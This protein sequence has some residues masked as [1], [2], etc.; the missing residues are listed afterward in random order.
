MFTS[1]F[2]RAFFSE[3]LLFFLIGTVL[4]FSEQMSEALISFFLNKSFFYTEPAFLKLIYILL[5]VVSLVLFTSLTRSGKLT[6]I[7]KK[8]ALS[9]YL[10]F[11]LMGWLIGFSAHNY[12]VY[13]EMMNTDS[14]HDLENSYFYYLQDMVLVLAFAIAGW[15]HLK[16]ALLKAQ[17]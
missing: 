9:G 16:P 4:F 5:G 3:L 12:L 13:D 6:V 10:L 15:V 14:L 7:E 2:Q 8:K 1:L 17:F 11:I